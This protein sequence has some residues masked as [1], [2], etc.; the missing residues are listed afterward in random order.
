MIITAK[1]IVRFWKFVDK[2]GPDECWLWKGG[3]DP[4]GYGR[5]RL[6]Y[7]RV[8][9][10]RVSY[11][12][13]RGAFEG[14]VLHKCDVTGC[15]NPGHLCRGTHLQNMND[16]D[17]K[18]RRPHGTRH[19]NAKLSENDVLA[20]VAAATSGVSQALLARQYNVNSRAI[21][22]IVTGIRWQRL[23]GIGASR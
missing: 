17:E 3:C 13:H 21:S 8:F 18:G 11:Q 4:H 19:W 5:F 22:K 9:A 16:C 14:H 23:T 1:D 6:K 20:I 15:V 10:H 7:K 12:I 2:R